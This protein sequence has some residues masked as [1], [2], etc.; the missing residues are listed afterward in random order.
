VWEWSTSDDEKGRHQFK[1]TLRDGEATFRVD[2][3]R[4]SEEQFEKRMEDFGVQFEKMGKN[5]EMAFADKKLFDQKRIRLIEKRA[6]EAAA[7]APEVR[8]DCDGD[9]ATSET[10]LAN[11]RKVIRIC[12]RR[13]AANAQASARAGLAQ[14]RAEIARN[15]AMSEEVRAEVLRELDQEIANLRTEGDD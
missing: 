13:I 14:A 10:T 15:R 12:E 6:S 5:M 1:R 7:M 9:E 8:M 3:E 4:L 2:G 11:G